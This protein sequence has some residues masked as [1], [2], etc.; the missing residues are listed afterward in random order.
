MS[1]AAAV[2]EEYEVEHMEAFRFIVSSRSR[3]N[4][5]HL[6]D[7][8]ENDGAGQ[9]SCEMFTFQ[10]QPKINRGARGE[11]VTCRHLRAVHRQFAQWAVQHAVKQRNE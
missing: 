11:A 10:C 2:T 8:E 5:G 3:L 9:C 7:L 6:V 1:R 4:I